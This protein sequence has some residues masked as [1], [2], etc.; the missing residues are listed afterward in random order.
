MTHGNED[1]R[2]VDLTGL[3]PD[4]QSPE[5]WAAL[6]A[7][8]ETA[9]APELARR[10]GRLGRLGT[11]EGI[12]AAL[13]RFA[14]PALVAA[15]AAIVIAVA[16]SRRAGDGAPA[17]MMAAVETLSDETVQALY[18]VDAATGLVAPQDTTSSEEL[19][20]A[21]YGDGEPE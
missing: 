13:A 3:W 14:G 15:A 1:E 19:V 9:A 4:R 2:P 16:A 12:A 10:A 7:R 21:L 20:R 17:D 5:R 11:A 18:G 6:V 8:I